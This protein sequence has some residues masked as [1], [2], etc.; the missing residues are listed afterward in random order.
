MHLQVLTLQRIQRKL[1][2]IELTRIIG[3]CAAG[4]SGAR[5]GGSSG[6]QVSSPRT[7][8]RCNVAIHAW[9]DIAS[10]E[11]A[12]IDR[13]EPRRGDLAR[14]KSVGGRRVRRSKIP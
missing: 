8:S 14:C 2:S 12:F 4:A 6:W 13:S 3:C 7:R 11:R 10:H 1:P 5:G 9:S